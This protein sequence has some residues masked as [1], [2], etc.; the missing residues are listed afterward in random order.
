MSLLRT[1]TFKFE[2]SQNRKSSGV[3]SCQTLKKK[4]IAFKILLL[5]DNSYVTWA[6]SNKDGAYIHSSLLEPNQTYIKINLS[7]LYAKLLLYTWCGGIGYL[8]K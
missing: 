7:K 3:I 5:I 8:I 1:S 6:I 4:K 2:P